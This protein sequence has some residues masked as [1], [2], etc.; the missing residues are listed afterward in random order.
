MSN[1]DA[2]RKAA[3]ERQKRYRQKLLQKED[4]QAAAQLA[5]AQEAEKAK[6]EAEAR[7]AEEAEARAAEESAVL[8]L[9][10]EQGL[11]SALA[12]TARMIVSA[13]NSATG[14]PKG[15]PTIS[16]GQAMAIAQLWTPVLK[17]LL[18]QHITSIAPLV[19]VAGTIGIMSEYADER[20][21]YIE[22]HEP[23]EAL[24]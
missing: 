16:G 19:A 6:Q 2:K 5:A 18:K 13:Y 8:E 9:E 3:A 20:A 1:K 22:K 21:N 7:A 24:N 23:K 11:T 17:P 15:T 14:C 12:G 4:P 10:L